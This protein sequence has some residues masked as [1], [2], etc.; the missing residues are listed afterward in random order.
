[1]CHSGAASRPRIRAPG[2]D[3]WENLTMHL[4]G[5][6]ISHRRIYLG[7]PEGRKLAGAAL[8]RWAWGLW[9]SVQDR[10]QRGC[11]LGLQPFESEKRHF[12]ILEHHMEVIMEKL[13]WSEHC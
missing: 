11:T 10:G 7:I 2:D 6:R 5:M 4:G 13:K 3:S 1:M 12:I 9:N 8:S